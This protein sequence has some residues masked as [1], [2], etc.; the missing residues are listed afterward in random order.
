MTALKWVQMYSILLIYSVAAPLVH[1]VKGLAQRHLRG[2]HERKASTAI[3]F[4]F[5]NQI[6]P[7]SWWIEKLY[8]LVFLFSRYIQPDIVLAHFLSVREGIW[9]YSVLTS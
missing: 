9:F 4:T 1:R 8:K 5:N 7:A 3:N 6:N 2:G